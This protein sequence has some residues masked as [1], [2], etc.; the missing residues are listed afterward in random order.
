MNKVTSL[1]SLW[2]KSVS[3][4]GEKQ[5]TR[6]TPHPPAQLPAVSYAPLTRRRS[7]GTPPRSGHARHSEEAA[8]PGAP[9]EGRAA[10]YSRLKRP[11]V[12]RAIA[13]GAA[14]IIFQLHRWARDFQLNA[15]SSWP[16]VPPPQ[17]EAASWLTRPSSHCPVQAHLSMPAREVRSVPEL[18]EGRKEGEQKE[19]EQLRSGHRVRPEPGP[20]LTGTGRQRHDRREYERVHLRAN[21]HTKGSSQCS[22][23]NYFL[24]SAA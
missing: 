23:R 3:N 17:G 20:R 1:D 11:S 19:D 12:P 22:R 2:R 10:T 21:V 7:S 18:S 4:F 24:P 6:V 16:R 9:G 5:G 14:A 13:A 8:G 15:C